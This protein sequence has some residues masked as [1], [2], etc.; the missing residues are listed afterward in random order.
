MTESIENKIVIKIKKAKRGAL[1][2]QIILQR[3][4]ILTLFKTQLAQLHGL[5]L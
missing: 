1:F 4:V 3:L 5:T 2:L